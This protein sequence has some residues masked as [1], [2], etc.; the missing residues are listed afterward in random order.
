M[1][2]FTVLATAA[3]AS[4]AVIGKRD[5]TFQVTD[6]SAG[7]IPHSTQCSYSFTVIQPGTM[8]TTGVKCSGLFPANNDGT[9]PDVKEGACTESSRTF[10][11]VRSPEGL[12]FS[13]SQPVTPSSNQT[14]THLIPAAQLAVSNEPNAVVEKY[15]GPVAFDLE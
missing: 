7:C 3:V 15:T 11:V 5:V 6:F 10:D 9:L 4:A 14:G 8:E 1:Q 2:F 12:T 13:V